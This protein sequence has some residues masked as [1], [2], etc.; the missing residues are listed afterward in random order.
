MSNLTDFI[1]G[2]SVVIKNSFD[3]STPTVIDTDGTVYTAPYTGD[4]LVGLVG[5][6]GGGGCDD[7]ANEGG[8]GGG[9]SGILYKKISMT[10]GTKVT[11]SIGAGGAGGDPDGATGGVT[12]FGS[13]FSVNGGTGGSSYHPGNGSNGGGNG[14]IGGNPGGHPGGSY[15]LPLNTHIPYALTPYMDRII[16]AGGGGGSVSGS[17]GGGGGAGYGGPGATG[18]TSAQYYGAGGG[19]AHDGDPSGGDGYQGVCII[20]EETQ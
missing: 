15:T 7:G 8:G 13:Y 14:G 1:G 18:G 17:K 9:G 3:N 6:G 2:S 4:Y 19:G 5:G 11:V 10:A 12:S 16:F 20:I